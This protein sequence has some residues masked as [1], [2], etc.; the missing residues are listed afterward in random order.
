[1]VT[2]PPPI[3]MP[4]SSL[5]KAFPNVHLESPLAQLEAFPS[6]PT[7][8]YMGEEADSHLATTSLQAVAES[9]KV[10]PESPPD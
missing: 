7:A 1:M 3:P 6:S 8:G 4:D 2:P 9:N 5:R 10:T